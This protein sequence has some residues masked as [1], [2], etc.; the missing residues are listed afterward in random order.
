MRFKVVDKCLAKTINIL[1]ERQQWKDSSPSWMIRNGVRRFY[2]DSFG[3]KCE[4]CGQAYNKI[5]RLHPFP[6][7]PSFG[8]GMWLTTDC[9][10]AI[11]QQQEIRS[12]IDQIR[13]D[14]I[15]GPVLPAAL[16]NHTFSNFRVESFNKDA[17]TRCKQFS[18]HFSKITDGRGLVLCGK[19]GRGKTHLACAI[20]NDLKD[21]NTVAFAHIPTLLENIRQGRGDLE[22]LLTVDLLVMDDLGSERE[23][24]W[25][26]E[27]LLII[28][29]GRLNAY[30]P[31]VFTTNFNLEELEVRVGSRL[32][33]RILY[34]SLDLV[35]QGPDWREI[36][37]KEKTMQK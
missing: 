11:K 5:Y 20:I 12:R 9:Q 37:F 23:S 16:Q 24:D 21:K 34:N 31:T 1:K 7:P 6:M 18:T 26:L 30:K 27:K 15:P 25:A 4:K 35:V 28:V 8:K 36:K 22:R 17:Y 29:D 32:A 13:V 2:P 10:C 14:T 33:S 3:L 19:S